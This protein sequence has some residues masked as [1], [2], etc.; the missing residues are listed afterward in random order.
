M[1]DDSRADRLPTAGR[2][3]SIFASLMHGRRLR[4]AAEHDRCNRC[5]SAN[6]ARAGTTT[7]TLFRLTAY[8]QQTLLAVAE[9]FKYSQFGNA[10]PLDRSPFSIGTRFRERVRCLTLAT[11]GSP[12]LSGDSRAFSL[13]KLAEAA[14]GGIA[15]A[16][17]RWS[18]G[19]GRLGAVF[20]GEDAG[21]AFGRVDYVSILAVLQG[22]EIDKIVVTVALL[23]LHIDSYFGKTGDL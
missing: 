20:S 1:P 12:A 22:Y 11:S 5:I 9:I 14:Y 7:C 10:E 13:R 3:R 2:M 4:R 17:G 23:Q 16:A 15:I 21:S 19:C 18:F 8:D 6:A